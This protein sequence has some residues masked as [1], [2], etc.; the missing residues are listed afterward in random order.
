MRKQEKKKGRRETRG[1]EK[2]KMEEKEREERGKYIGEKGAQLKTRA[3]AQ[4]SPGARTVSSS[5]L[6]ADAFEL[7]CQA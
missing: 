5:S 4:T 3:R 2:V 6:A 1:E 7:T